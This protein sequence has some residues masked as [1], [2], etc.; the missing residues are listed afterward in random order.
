MGGSIYFVVE[1]M[2]TSE[3]A[4]ERKRIRYHE[5][6]KVIYDHY[7]WKCACCGEDEILFLCLDHINNDGNQHARDAGFKDPRRR[8]GLEMY[9]WII[10][11]NFP[12][13]FQ[14]L[15]FN[16]NNGKHRNGG[17]CPHEKNNEEKTLPDTVTTYSVTSAV[18]LDSQPCVG[19]KCDWHRENSDCC[20]GS[21]FP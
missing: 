16:C 21:C 5:V 7:G 3:A 19:R 4:R 20:T 10:A 14:V 11:N 13:I 18:T 1:I 15:C 8:G 2:K 9:R 6:K 12:P 17:V